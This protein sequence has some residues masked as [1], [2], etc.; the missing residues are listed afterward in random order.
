MSEQP[1][2]PSPHDTIGDE[3]IVLRDGRPFI[4]RRIRPGDW[5]QLISLVARLSPESRRFR[6]FTPKRHIPPDFARRLSIVDFIDRAAFVGY[7]AGEQEIRAVGR[8]ESEAAASPVAEVAFVVEDTLH[9]MG[10]A[11]HLLSH[12]RQ[13]AVENGKTDF[14]ANVLAEN[15]DMLEV[16]RHAHPGAVFTYERDVVHVAM[17]L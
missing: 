14:I 5:V 3:P 2:L 8:Y 15:T 9:G 10:I 1:P 16:F 11:T 7:F 17:K 6:F 12:L 13:L 4:I